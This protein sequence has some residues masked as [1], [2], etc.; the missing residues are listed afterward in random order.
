MKSVGGSVRRGRAEDGRPVEHDH[1]EGQT[2]PLEG[3]NSSCFDSAALELN[4]SD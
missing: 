2:A 1:L 3:T 4:V